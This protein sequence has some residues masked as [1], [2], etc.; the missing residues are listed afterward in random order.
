MPLKTMNVAIKVLPAIA[1]SDTVNL[2]MSIEAIDDKGR[3]LAITSPEYKTLL[4]DVKRIF[5]EDKDLREY[6][7]SE[8]KNLSS[9]AMN[10][11]PNLVPGWMLAW[12]EQGLA[13][14]QLKTREDWEMSHARDPETGKPLRKVPVNVKIIDLQGKV[15]EEEDKYNWSIVNLLKPLKTR[16]SEDWWESVKDNVG[17]FP[18]SVRSGMWNFGKNVV[19]KA[20]HVAAGLDTRTASTRASITDT[21]GAVGARMSGAAAYVTDQVKIASSTRALKTEIAKIKPTSAEQYA[22]A[23][24][25]AIC[26][27]LGLPPPD[28]ANRSIIRLDKTDDNYVYGRVNG[29]INDTL[30]TAEEPLEVMRKG[31]LRVFANSMVDVYSEKRDAAMRYSRKR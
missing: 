28:A 6:G 23:I 29:W 8:V 2:E 11:D 30:D 9:I 25:E 15:L 26:K 13:L 24:K 3:Q 16:R 21:A 12:V 14:S 27:V 5:Q 19:E 4:E 20:T 22:T 7:V 18:S 1:G 17:D 31:V 10:V